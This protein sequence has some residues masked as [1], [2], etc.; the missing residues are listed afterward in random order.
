MSTVIVT[1]RRAR[2]LRGMSLE[3]VADVTLINVKFLR[4]LD[5]GQFSILPEAYVRAFLRGY[6]SA[7]GLDPAEVMKEFDQD[8]APAP[9]AVEQRPVP[10][11]PS[12]PL[13]PP[14]PVSEISVEIC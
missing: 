1:L 12:P 2:E 7:V 8:A 3:D 10:P 4:A 6:A 14:S 9:P 13:V 5:A 11:A